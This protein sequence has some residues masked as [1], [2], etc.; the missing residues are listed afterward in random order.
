MAKFIIPEE[1]ADRFW[2]KVFIRGEDEC[3][4]YFGGTLDKRGKG[5]FHFKGHKY[6]AQRFAFALEYEYMPEEDVIHT[7]NNISCVNPK[8]LTVPSYEEEKKRKQQE[9]G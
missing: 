7:C 1:D 6:N 9:Q 3:W 5:R 4:E 2:S 8:H